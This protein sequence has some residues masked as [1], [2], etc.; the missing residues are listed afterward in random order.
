M[1]PTTTVPVYSYVAAQYHG[2]PPPPTPPCV[3]ALP[4][5]RKAQKAEEDKRKQ[6]LLEQERAAKV[7]QKKKKS[8]FFNQVMAVAT[9]VAYQTESLAKKGYSEASKAVYNQVDERA[10]ARF[11]VQFPALGKDEKLLWNASGKILSGGAPISGEVFISA[12]HLCFFGIY[13]DAKSVPG[14]VIK[15]QIQA[16]VPLRLIVCI[17]PAIANFGT[18]P[19][20]APVI[21]PVAAN[22]VPTALMVFCSDRSIHLIYGLKEFGDLHLVLDH[23][24]RT[25]V[26][27]FQ[28]VQFHPSHQQYAPPVA[29]QHQFAQNFAPSAPPA[30]DSD[31]EDA[32]YPDLKK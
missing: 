30:A 8:G 14:S 21:T 6:Q 17:Q 15:H 12:N 32:L 22:Q 10:S 9:D 16:C 18:D 11:H 24:W 23:Q 28:N 1:N 20:A 26:S 27:T 3:G 2:N 19:L 5:V 25:H 13:R 29:P 31:D 7:A 4:W